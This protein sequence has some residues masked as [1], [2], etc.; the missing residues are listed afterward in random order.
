MS[1][2]K[3]SEKSTSS[4]EDSPVRTCRSQ[5][6]VPASL[7]R[8]AAC[9]GRCSESSVDA[10]LVGFCGR[11]FPDFY[12]PTE[13]KPSWPSSARLPRAGISAPG[14]C[15]TPST[16]EWPNG[17][18]ECTA[19]SLATV[20]EPSVPPRFYLSPKA[21][22]GIVRRAA[23]RGKELPPNLEKVLRAVASELPTDD[24][25]D[26]DKEKTDTTV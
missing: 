22:M 25:P 9:G 13:E 23:R 16:S 14:G 19:C 10:I 8:E 20:L 3:T 24:E 26:Q 17:E 21:C 1:D 15:W 2:Q 11:M 12:L 6:S 7:V 5:A 18:G 4:S